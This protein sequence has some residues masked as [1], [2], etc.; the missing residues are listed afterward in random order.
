MITKLDNGLTVI[1][2]ESH[3]APVVAFQAWVNVGSADEE[4]GEEGLAHL[5]E[6]MIFKGTQKRGVGQIAKEV[7]TAGGEINAFTSFDQTVYH[8]TLSSRDIDLGLDILADAIQNSSFSDHDLKSEIEVILEEIKRS[9]DLPA[10]EASKYLFE[11]TYQIHPYRRPVIGFVDTVKNLTPAVIRAFHG[12]WYVP[13]NITIVVCG[14]FSSKQ[15]LEKIQKL[16][17]NLNGSIAQKRSRKKEPKQDMI[18]FS[19]NEGMTN[20]IYLNS[21]FHIPSITHHDVPTL[22]LLSMILGQGDNSRLWRELRIK[23]GLVSQVYA[24]TYTPKDPGIFVIGATFQNRSTTEI[25][26]EL[27][28]TLRGIRYDVVSNEEL[29][30]AKKNI[31][32]ELT[33][34]K[35]TVD[36]LAKSRGYYQTNTGDPGFEEKYHARVSGV[37]IEDIEGVAQRYLTENNLTIAHYGPKKLSSTESEKVK[38]LW[39]KIFYKKR[40]EIKKRGKGEFVRI[41]TPGG[42][43]VVLKETPEI[44]VTAIRSAFMGGIRYERESNNGISSLIARILPLGTKRRDE[45]SVAEEIESMAAAMEGFAGRNS[46][47][48]AL[49]TLSRHNDKAIDLF[50][51]VL[52]SPAFDASVLKREKIEIL[53]EIKAQEDNPLSLVARLFTKTL[54]KK[55][56]YRLEA[57]GTKGSLKNIGQP[58]LLQFHKNLFTQKALVLSVVGDIKIDTL[59]PKIENYISLL[60]KHQTPAIRLKPETSP[61]E[62]RINHMNLQKQ[63]EHIIVGFLGGQIS[64]KD[65]YSLRVLISLLSGQSGRL[66]TE[67]REKRS[68]AY[69]VAPFS[70]EG[71][72]PGTLAFYIA[73]SPEK[74]NDALK[75]MVD[76]IKK[77]TSE[78][79]KT[80]ELNRAKHFLAGRYEIDL[81]KCAAQAAVV[82]FDELYGLG[83]EECKKFPEEIYKVTADE[84]LETAQKYLRLQNATIASVGPKRPTFKG[85]DP[86]FRK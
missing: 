41:V 1:L 32:S 75:V 68:F 20:E 33:Y 86:I 22:D 52:G 63:Q 49:E 62:P 77:I 39:K 3:K 21:A 17:K 10:R 25:F 31:E 71:I 48:L 15:V 56:P 58:E 53:N 66:F 85:S 73:C 50:F 64:G 65:R 46:M 43:T 27:L 37:K 54:F 51:E 74:S 78:K 67:L 83:F 55:H 14:N 59:M 35:E 76:E 61:K 5:F 23:K 34:Q 13:G 70:V 12:K 42:A 24:G 60:P 2:E 19:T 69:T 26:E 45:L 6:H 11:T 80:G 72:E 30:V 29:E 16:F 40:A 84:I 82:A 36:G 44:G 79:I 7:E 8:L 57:L 9:E 28:L 47:G 81:Q 38:A 18:R 4:K